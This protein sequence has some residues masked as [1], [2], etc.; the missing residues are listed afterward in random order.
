MARVELITWSDLIEHLTDWMGANPSGEARR[1]AKR[2]SLSALRAVANA[3]SWTYYY[4]RGRLNTVAAYSAGTVS[5]DQTG[6]AFERLVTLAGGTF[7]SW[8]ALG[9]VQIENVTYEVAERKSDTQVTLSTNSNP[10]AD[11]AGTSGWT[12]YRESY[13]LPTNF[14][15]LGELYI[16]THARLLGFEHPSNW[17]ARQRV[18]RGVSIPSSYTVLGEANYQNVLA[19]AFYPPPDLAYA[20][21]YLYK[22]HP[23]PLRVEQETAGKVSVG[24]GSA[25]VTGAGTAFSSRMVGSVIRIGDASDV[26]TARWGNSPAQDERVVTAVASATSL[27]VDSGWSVAANGV[28]YA[29]SDPVD[30]HAPTMLTALLRRAELETGHARNKR[31]RGELEM[32]AQRELVM[33]READARNFKE[34]RAGSPGLW[35]VRY[36]DM[37]FD[38]SGG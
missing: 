21:D 31:D 30:I 13:P 24:V 32:A 11:I 7:P 28:K 4:T 35:P 10:G 22:R 3:H 5:Y 27:T 26:P 12:I 14:Q 1:D 38:A 19:I 29:I 25:S 33:A 2:A 34:E 8:A 36:A 9:T 17:L 15:S 23:R 20:V 16:A 18:Y 37:P 6:G